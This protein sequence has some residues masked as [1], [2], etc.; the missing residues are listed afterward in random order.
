MISCGSDDTKHISKMV[1]QYQRHSHSN[2]CRWSHSCQFG[3]PKAPS[4]TTLICREPEDDEKWDEI[5]KSACHILSKV[6]NIIDSTSN[7]LNL[8]DVLQQAGVSEEAYISPLKVT[9][10]GLKCNIE[11]KASRCLYKWM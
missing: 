2:Y 7:E 3:F 10:R 1:R 9:C 8:V 4:L 6:Y 5:L 11:K